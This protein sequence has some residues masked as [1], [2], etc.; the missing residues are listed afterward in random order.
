MHFDRDEK[1]LHAPYES[2]QVCED[3][4]RQLGQAYLLSRYAYEPHLVSIR[5]ETFESGG[6]LG[7]HA[8]DGSRGEASCI[9]E[10]A[11]PLPCP[12]RATFLRGRCRSR[13]EH[14]LITK[15]PH[16]IETI[17]ERILLS[18]SDDHAGNDMSNAH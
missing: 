12:G 3:S 2:Q 6:R 9:R 8:K 16:Q 13:H 14:D 10:L 7:N 4:S 11:A 15:I 1:E 18:S 17:E 5:L